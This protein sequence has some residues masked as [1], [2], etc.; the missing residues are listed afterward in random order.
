MEK[1][2]EN[3]NIK[4][5]IA[6]SKNNSLRNE[7]IMQLK[8]NYLKMYFNPNKNHAMQFSIKIEPELQ[9]DNY[10]IRKIIRLG[11]S[12][13]KNNFTKYFQSGLTL[14]A[15]ESKQDKLILEIEHE[16]MKYKIFIEKTKNIRIK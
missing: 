13:L 4:F 15:N 7:E 8:T 9:N 16:E 10:L 14:F 11:V 6:P 3:E 5:Q 12:N 2:E 1:K